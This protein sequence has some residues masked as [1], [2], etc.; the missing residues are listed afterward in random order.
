MLRPTFSGFQVAKRGLSV[1]QK[2]LDVT[3]QN[4]TNINTDGYT[5]Q[6]V[7]L[8]SISFSSGSSHYSM[9]PG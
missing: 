7:D 2:L 1:S 4:I 6:R 5:R 9:F 3:G 8:Y